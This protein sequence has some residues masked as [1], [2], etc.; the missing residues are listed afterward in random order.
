MARAVLIILDGVGI[1]G[2]PDAAAYGDDGSDTLGNLARAV[3]GLDLPVLASLGL[4]NCHEIP[5]VGPVAQPRA[6]YGALR[7]ISAGKDSTAGHWE[8]MGVVTETPFPTYPQGFPADV[9]TAFREATG[10]DF[11][12]NVVASGTEII[13]RLG[14]EH[15]RTG[16]PIVY[17][18]ADSVFQIAAHEDVIPLPKLYDICE[19]SRRLLVPPHQ[20]SRVIARPFRGVTGAYARTPNRRDF[21]VAPPSHLVL[22]ALREAGVEVATVGK[23][24]DLY[25]GQGI[26][27]ALKSKSNAEGLRV[28]DELYAAKPADPAL[29]MLNLVDFDTLWGHRNDPEG[30]RD[31]LV[32][33]DRWLAGFLEALAGGDLLLLT[34]DHGNDPTTPSTDHSREHVPLLACLGGNR[35]GVDLGLRE[36]FADVG[37]TIAEHFRARAPRCGTSFLPALRA[38]AA[39]RTP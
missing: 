31:G 16:K 7:E 23:I 39:R 12:G 38:A 20:V 15:V 32:V 8:L 37:A 22:H 25:A 19:A 5:G 36:T 30:F 33:F 28:L 34:A 2:A 18:S 6:G 1:G 11:L 35:S 14:D 13:E 21:S 10:V 29:I 17:T 9:M 27:R 26:D 4:G 3:G 24:F